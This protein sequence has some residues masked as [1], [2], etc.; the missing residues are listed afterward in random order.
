MVKGSP[1]KGVWIEEEVAMMIAIGDVMVNRWSRVNTATSAVDERE[2]APSGVKFESAPWQRT[3]RD[4]MEPNEL[5]KKQPKV[6]WVVGGVRYARDPSMHLKWVNVHDI[7]VCIRDL[8]LA[9]ES[10]QRSNHCTKKGITVAKGWCTDSSSTP[11]NLSQKLP[12]YL[13][14]LKGLPYSTLSY[15][16]NH[17]K[18]IQ[19]A[20]TVSVKRILSHSSSQPKKYI[21]RSHVTRHI[22]L[23]GKFRNVHFETT[24]HLV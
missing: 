19:V 15:A 16:F 11:C 1:S 13:L 3:C 17:T 10:L 23:I 24:L 2:G 20:A 18:I 21:L 8:D 7:R 12:S 9:G 5:S 6:C 22:D 14:I 4:V